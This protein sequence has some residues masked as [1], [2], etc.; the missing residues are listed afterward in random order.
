MFGASARKRP[1]SAPQ[2]HNNWLDLVRA[3]AILLVLVTHAG[4]F[5]AEQL[6]WAP[7]LML[8][9]G[10]LG[11]E[12][13]FVLSGFL[14]G[15]I[16][17]GLADDFSWWGLRR[18]LVRRWLR[19]LPNYYLFLL[20]N[21][22]LAWTLIRP[23]PLDEVGAYFLFMQNLTG[24]HPWFFPEAWSL[25]IEE[26]FYFGF[27]LISLLIALLLR[28][29]PARAML[30]VGLGVLA[31]S[32]LGRL[33]LATQPGLSWDENIRK[34]VWLRLDGLMI[35]VLAAFHR[36]RGGQWLERTWVRW[37]LLGL[38]IA[39]AWYAW[40]GGAALLNRAYFAKTLLFNTTSLGCLGLILIGLAWPLPAAVARPAGFLARV[41]FSA[42]LVNLPVAALLEHLGWGSPW[43]RV[44]LFLVLTIGL[45]WL[46][47]RWWERRFLRLRDHLEVLAAGRRRARASRE[48][49]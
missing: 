14:I 49:A 19:T 25:S 22:I 2:N 30:W 42:Y 31:F 37:A 18:F 28:L 24:A 15:R 21:L 16:L 38:L 8:V 17:L 41:S 33:W 27:P 45:S 39:S 40:S 23:A 20:I 9:P 46:V 7:Q 47:Y 11:V 44:A 3:L 35:G 5:L 12:L 43:E 26:V 36:G 29:P 13:F 32:T 48:V 10:F 34:V 4:G 1:A 6:A